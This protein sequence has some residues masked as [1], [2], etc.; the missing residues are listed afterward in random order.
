MV[1]SSDANA[2]Y[3]MD[4]IAKV[5]FG[6]ITTTG[7]AEVA[8]KQVVR[9]VND[10]MELSGFAAGTAVSVYDLNVRH[11]SSLRTRADGTLNVSLAA[12]EA[13]IYIIKADKITFAT[14]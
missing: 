6:D 9:F 2:T 10:G 14:N 11:V 3:P 7:I 4:L 12:C 1:T 5:F 8:N 13:S